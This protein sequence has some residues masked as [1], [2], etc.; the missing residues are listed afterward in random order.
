MR[1][2]FREEITNPSTLVNL[3]DDDYWITFGLF[4][5]T[6]NI[7]SEVCGVLDSFFYFQKKLKKEKFTTCCL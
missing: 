7:R 3:I 1:L 4:L 2:K 5:F 6:S